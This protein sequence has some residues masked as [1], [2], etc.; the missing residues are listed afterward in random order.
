MCDVNA[1]ITSQKKTLQ[2]V[3]KNQ[4]SPCFMADKLSTSQTI[5]SPEQT[6]YAPCRCFVWLVK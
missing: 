3:P 4:G 5:F 1:F 2:A 6:I